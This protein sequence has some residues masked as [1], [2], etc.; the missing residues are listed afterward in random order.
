MTRYPG[1]TVI[2]FMKLQVGRALVTPPYALVLV[3]RDGAERRYS[4]F[5]ITLGFYVFRPSPMAGFASLAS[6]GTQ[7]RFNSWRSA[8]PGLR[9]IGFQPREWCRG[10]PLLLTLRKLS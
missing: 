10:H 3:S 4:F 5:Q 2:G 9:L 1:N 8:F 7:R 6:A